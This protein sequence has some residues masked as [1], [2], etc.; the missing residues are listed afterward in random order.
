[1]MRFVR[2]GVLVVAIGGA[3]FL[4]GCDDEVAPPTPLP[5]P[6]PSVRAV[7]Y[8]TADQPS[9]PFTNFQPGQ[10]YYVPIPLGQPG[11]LDFTLDWTFPNTYMLMAFGT[12]LCSFEDLD[13]GRCPFIVRTEGSTPKPRVMT[14]TALPTGTYYLYLYSQPW[15][16]RLGY[17]N[18]AIESLALTIGLTVGPAVTSQTIPIEPIRL[19]P[20]FI[21]Q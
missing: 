12:Q 13:A 15:D 7:V 17:G 9:Q 14:T 4:P 11:R 5:T 2:R 3:F 18:D 21:G 20:R 16:P 1:M 6:V 10:L 19:Q 8:S